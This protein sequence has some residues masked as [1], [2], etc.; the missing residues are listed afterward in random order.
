MKIK[1][2]EQQGQLIAQETID[3]RKSVD[4]YIWQ[5]SKNAKKEAEAFIERTFKPGEAKEEVVKHAYDAH[6]TRA[7][8]QEMNRLTQEAGI[9]FVEYHDQGR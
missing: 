1:K 6:H 3:Y 8:H 4:S 7:F 2:Q 5:A 9:R